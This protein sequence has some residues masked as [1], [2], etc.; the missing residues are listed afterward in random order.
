MESIYQC[1][2]SQADRDDRN[3]REKE[4]EFDDDDDD[5]LLVVEQLECPVSEAKL[6]A[7]HDSDRPNSGTSYTSGKHVITF[8]V[9]ATLKICCMC[10]CKPSSTPVHSITVL[11]CL[12]VLCFPQLWA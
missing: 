12:S 1:H 5:E 3:K 9:H 6:W 11:I 8:T 2:M 4:L 7:A 10:I